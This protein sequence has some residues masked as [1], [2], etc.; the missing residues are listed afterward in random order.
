M[1]ITSKQALTSILFGFN[2]V[3]D[4]C[5][6]P[7]NRAASIVAYFDLDTSNKEIKAIEASIDRN[8][9]YLACYYDALYDVKTSPDFVVQDNNGYDIYFYKL[10][11]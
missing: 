1:A 2:D 8:C 7:K 11:N 10:I 6:L 9:D 4:I 5:I 3:Q